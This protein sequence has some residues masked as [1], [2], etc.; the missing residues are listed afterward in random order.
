MHLCVRNSSSVGIASTRLALTRLEA[1]AVK[2]SSLVAPS[3][4]PLALPKTAAAEEL[5]GLNP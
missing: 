3:P 1:F 4:P 2:R 5:S